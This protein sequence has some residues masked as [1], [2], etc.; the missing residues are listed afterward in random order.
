MIRQV[1]EHCSVFRALQA[2][3]FERTMRKY[4]LEDG[5]IRGHFGLANSTLQLQGERL[6][7]FPEFLK[8]GAHSIQNNV[9]HESYKKAL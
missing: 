9:T 5:L 6:K 1:P 4:A 7:I 2:T 3:K 8:K